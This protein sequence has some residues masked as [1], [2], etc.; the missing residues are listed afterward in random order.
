MS[1]TMSSL[2]CM[3]FLVPQYLK[4]VQRLQ[5]LQNKCIRFVLNLD[6]RSYLDASHFKRLNWFPVRKRVNFISL[7]HVYKNT[8]KTP[9]YLYQHFTPATK[10]RFSNNGCFAIPKVKGFC[11]K[12]FA[13]NGCKLWNS[14]PLSVKDQ[15]NLMKFKHAIQEL[16][17]TDF[18]ICS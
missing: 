7:T 9:E 12:T 3:L 4:Q 5:I 15:N 16:T 17:Y 6:S 2:L 14:L 1:Y 8:K 10:T 13:Y 18:L 11:M